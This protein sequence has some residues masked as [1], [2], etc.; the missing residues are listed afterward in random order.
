MGIDHDNVYAFIVDCFELLYKMNLVEM[1]SVEF[2][3]FMFCKGELENEHQY[4]RKY[5]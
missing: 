3:T 2:G 4:F 1:I 5:N